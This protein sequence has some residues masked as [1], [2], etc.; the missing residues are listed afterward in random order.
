MIDDSYA[1]V[2]P[3]LGGW[4]TPT[5]PITESLSALEAGARLH[6]LAVAGDDNSF[7][8]MPSFQYGAPE[9]GGDVD[10]MPCPEPKWSRLTVPKNHSQNLSFRVF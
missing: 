6:N 8:P 3:P 1:P 7:A 2:P 10:Y 4:Q 9:P 5:R